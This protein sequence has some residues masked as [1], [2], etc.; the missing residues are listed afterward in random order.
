M[1]Y[2]LCFSG[3]GRGFSL[4]CVSVCCISVGL[5]FVLVG[6]ILCFTR[7][8]SVFLWVMSCVSVALAVDF[9]PVLCFSGVAICPNSNLTF[10][11]LNLY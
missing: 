8:W 2:V 10:I 1:G 9:F 5:P 3:F 4:C 11:A 6:N 7:F